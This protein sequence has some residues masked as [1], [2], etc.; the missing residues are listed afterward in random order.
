MKIIILFIL[1][2]L[3]ILSLLFLLIK[4]SDKKGKKK[5]EDEEKEDEEKE[6]DDKECKR[7]GTLCKN[8]NKICDYKNNKLKCIIPIKIVKDIKYNDMTDMKGD[9]YY[10]TKN[11]SK[12]K[13]IIIIHGGGL[14]KGSKNNDR[15]VEMAVDLAYNGYNIFIPEYTLGKNSF[16]QNTKDVLASIN[17]MKNKF[18]CDKIDIL[19][20]SAGSTLV[21]LTAIYNNITDDVSNLILFYGISDPLTRFYTETTTKK[22]QGDFRPGHLTE[23]LGTKMCVS[24]KSDISHFK[25]KNLCQ[26][27]PDKKITYHCVADIWKK[28][29]PIRNINNETILPKIILIHGKKDKIVN[30]EQSENL[31]N[32]LKSLNKNINF[33]SIDNGS[34]GFNFYSNKNDELLLNKNLLKNILN[35]IN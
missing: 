2:I 11:V 30:H 26:D 19:G 23:V 33:I 10:S 7:V 32:Y 28:Y 12:N 9:L 20:L 5:E 8:I 6:E 22:E 17:Y 4:Y 14:I 35:I 27:K 25:D 24:C 13:C 21:L 3:S 16:E 1:F 31:Y 34:H 18:K 29:S 15:E